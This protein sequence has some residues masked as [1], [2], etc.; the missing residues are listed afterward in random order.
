MNTTNDFKNELK[1]NIDCTDN[2]TIKKIL[3]LLEVKPPTIWWSNG[4][5]ED[6]WIETNSLITESTEEKR[7]S[8]EQIK[9]MYPHWFKD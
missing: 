3:E 1:E 2:H 8:I 6:A 9:Q 7:L 4:P 5:T